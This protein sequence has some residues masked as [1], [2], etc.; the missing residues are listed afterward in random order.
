MEE[1]KQNNIGCGI[2]IAI[3]VIVVII[4]F[5]VS[6]DDDSS[7]SKYSDDYIYDSDYRNDVDEVGGIFGEDSADVDSAI[8]AVVD[9][10]NS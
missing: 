1:K 4:V 5:A 10:M 6:G 2:I 7:S 3:I 8:Q 9:E